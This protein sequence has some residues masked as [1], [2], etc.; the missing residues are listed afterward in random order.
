MERWIT[1]M[2]QKKHW[3]LYV[4]LLFLG[5]AVGALL[6]TLRPTPALP[7]KES[8]SIS[9]Q[10]GNPRNTPVVQAVKKS[11]PAVVGI[12]NKAYAKDYFNRTVQTGEGIGSGVIFDSRGYIVTNFHVIDGASE[13]IVSLAD[14]R[15]FPAQLVGGDPATDLAVVKIEATD[16]P[17]AILGDSDTLQIGEP[18]IAIGNPLG[19]E[20]QGTVT[21]GVISAL[22]RTI[23]FGD[24]QFNLIQTDAAINPGNSGGALINA[25]GELIG[26]NSAKIAVSGVEGIG[27]AIPINAAQ[28]ILKAL[29]ENGKVSRPYLGAGLLDQQSAARYGYQLPVGK[30]RL[31]G[32]LVAGGPAQKAGIQPGDI[33]LSV[34]GQEVGG[35]SKLRKIL[36]TSQIGDVVSVEISRNGQL[37]RLEVRLEEPQ[38]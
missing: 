21:V 30:G 2:N 35:I 32:S 10:N 15:S 38:Q 9:T 37:K 19:L 14:G 28:P 6:F 8:M 17:V 5:F 33:L 34:S 7:V 26:I 12:T 3:W 31:V 16:L 20:F 13:L 22:K 1:S 4:L 11:G 24:R 23:D 29:M 25:A 18:A 36:E 27:F